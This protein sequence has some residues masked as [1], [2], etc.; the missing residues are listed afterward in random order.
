M[1]AF[2]SDIHDLSRS[3]QAFA[4][5]RPFALNPAAHN[6]ARAR[7]NFAIAYAAA[8]LVWRLAIAYTIR[9]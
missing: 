9:G 7:A 4:P 8:A 6:D 3:Q 5:S 2:R 1:Q